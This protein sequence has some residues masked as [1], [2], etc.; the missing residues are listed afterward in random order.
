MSAQNVLQIFPSG[1]RD[2]DERGSVGD[3][4]KEVIEPDWPRLAMPLSPG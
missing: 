1:I 2:N 4:L 3:F